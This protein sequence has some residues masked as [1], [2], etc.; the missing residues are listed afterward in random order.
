MNTQRVELTELPRPH[1]QYIGRRADVLPVGNK[2]WVMNVEITG[3]EKVTGWLVVQT[4]EGELS[5]P[6]ALSSFLFLT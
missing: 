1:E 2:P 4:A 3:I 5:I 6:P